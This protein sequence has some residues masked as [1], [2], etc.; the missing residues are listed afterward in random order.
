M[1]K[2]VIAGT[3]LKTPVVKHFFGEY[4]QLK[5]FYDDVSTLSEG[6]SNIRHLVYSELEKPNSSNLIAQ[7]SKFGSDKVSKHS[8]GDLY[9]LILSPLEMTTLNFLEIGIH[10]GASLRAI[11]SR[12]TKWNVFGVDIRQE[13][14]INEGMISSYLVNQFSDQDWALFRSRIDSR[15][16]TFVID[17]GFHTF[18]SSLIS[19]INLKSCLLDNFTYFVED[20][21]TS[22]LQKWMLFAATSPEY[23]FIFMTSGDKL[24]NNEDDNMVIITFLTSPLASEVLHARL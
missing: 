1:L 16:F 20:V 22:D 17:D 12:F 14:L 2:S 19:F 11:S 8:Y 23:Q 15:K 13:C 5:M 9:E 24:P 7:F 18:Q 4:L 3:L 6:K 10:R 21:L